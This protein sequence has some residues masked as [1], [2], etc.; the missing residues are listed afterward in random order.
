MTDS[1]TASNRSTDQIAAVVLAAGQSRRMGTPKLVLPWGSRTVIG[2]VVQTL[3]DGGI[4]EIVVVTGG[5]WEAVEAVLKDTPVKLVRNQEFA[6]SEMVASLQIGIRSLAPACQVALIALGDQPTIDA[7]VVQK[8]VD[9]YLQTGASIII[10]SYQMRRGHP[11]LVVRSLWPDILALS[12]NQTM[13]D[14]LQSHV[15][16][17]AY[18]QI[19]IPGIILDLDTPEEYNRLRPTI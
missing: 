5:A 15:D 10:P 8:L 13:R 19:N 17:I 11:W 18:I 16:Q 1:V 2:Q 14:F 12:K 7:E 6:N 9:A 4:S 3:F